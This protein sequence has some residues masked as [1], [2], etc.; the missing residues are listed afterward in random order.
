MSNLPSIG[1]QTVLYRQGLPDVDR[2]VRSLGNAVRLT[3]RIG[4]IGSVSLII[5]DCSPTATLT[6]EHVDDLR[7][8]L[9]ASGI[10]DIKYDYFG[11]NLGSAAGHNRLL[12][13]NDS[14]YVLFIIPDAFASPFLLSELLLPHHDSRVGI[15]EARQ[16]PLE[17][18]KT[19]DPHSG[20]TSWASTAGCLVRREVIDAIGGFDAT[21]FFLYCDDVD[22]SWRARLAGFRVLLQPGARLFHDK[23]L[24]SDG[25]MVIGDA[26]H[27]FAAEAALMLAWK[28]SRGDLVDQ[29]LDALS[30][31][32][33]PLQVEAAANFLR[34]RDDGSLPAQLD[35]QGKVAEFHGINF[36]RH[37]FE[38][39]A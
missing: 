8:R 29:W 31:S 17:H 27:Y 7:R 18:P 39:G 19:F 37:R 36:A 21:S 5:G 25:M 6:L 4:E 14:K 28:Y 3:Q 15:V 11:Q 24:T 38:Y 30:R 33:L 23:R 10:N 1:I 12:D 13:V 22:F 34:R 20:E 9:I 16:V 35:P 32:D 2:L 26:E